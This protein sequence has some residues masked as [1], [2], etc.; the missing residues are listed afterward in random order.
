MWFDISFG[1]TPKRQFSALI[2][3]YKFL[4]Q[5]KSLC[6]NLIKYILFPKTSSVFL[7]FHFLNFNL[8]Y[9]LL[10]HWLLLWIS[11][12]YYAANFLHRY[13]LWV[14]SLGTFTRS[15][16]FSVLQ[17]IN[18]DGFLYVTLWGVLINNNNVWN[19]HISDMV[20]RLRWIIF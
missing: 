9:L 18:S 6:Y 3:W 11:L 12:L 20:M 16:F 10:T 8:N 5:T 13:C 19:I 15:K 4:F 14:F 1:S 2:I 17:K 7:V